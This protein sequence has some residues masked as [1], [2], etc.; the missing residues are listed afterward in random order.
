MAT[1]EYLGG[2]NLRLTLDGE[3]YAGKCKIEKNKKP[4]TIRWEDGGKWRR[5]THVKNKNNSYFFFESIYL[6]L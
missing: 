4:N 5:T 6:F 2:G 1:I 3:S